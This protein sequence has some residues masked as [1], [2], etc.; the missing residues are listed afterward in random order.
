MYMKAEGVSAFL[1]REKPKDK[2]EKPS[3]NL[4]QAGV[5]LLDDLNSSEE[6]ELGEEFE[7]CQAT[8]EY[9]ILEKLFDEDNHKNLIIDKEEKKLA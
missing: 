1:K 7:P 8:K 2:S 5:N 9:G 6:F 3:E 4:F